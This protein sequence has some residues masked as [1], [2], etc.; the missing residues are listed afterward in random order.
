MP[1]CLGPGRKYRLMVNF[2]ITLVV[3]CIEFVDMCILH[4]FLRPTNFNFGKSIFE[5]FHWA[6]SFCCPFPHLF[7]NHLT[8]LCSLL[9]LKQLLASSDTVGFHCGLPTPSPALHS[10]HTI[11]MQIQLPRQIQC[12]A[13]FSTKKVQA[14][15]QVLEQTQV[16]FT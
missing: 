11:L 6:E 13:S 14:H 12:I 4:I 5:S 15:I 2:L 10:L 1:A 16:L 3:L 9:H 8:S 7:K